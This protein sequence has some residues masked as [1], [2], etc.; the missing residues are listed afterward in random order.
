MKNNISKINYSDFNL[1]IVDDDEDILISYTQNLT[2]LGYKVVCAKNAKEAVRVVR[3]SKEKETE[4][5]V[6]VIDFY[7]PEYSGGDAVKEIREFNKEIVIL[8]Q[9]GFAGD[10]PA[11][12]TLESLKI[13]AYHD[14]TQG[15]DEF[16]VRIISCIRTYMQQRRIAELNKELKL[17]YE[18]IEKLKKNQSLLINATKLSTKGQLIS[19]LPF[20]L[21]STS[22]RS[23]YKIYELEELIE[24]ILHKNVNKD[25]SCIE[26]CE[27]YKKEILAHIESVKEYL[28]TDNN[29]IMSASDDIKEK[30]N[31]YNY[32][33]I[34][35]DDPGA[36]AINMIFGPKTFQ[37]LK[38][39]NTELISGYQSSLIVNDKSLGDI[40]KLKLNG[41]ISVILQVIYSITINLA[42][43]M[44][45]F[46]D[47]D[48][49]DLRKYHEPS[50]G[51]IHMFFIQPANNAPEERKYL[52]FHIGVHNKDIKEKVKENLINDC[53]NNGIALGLF[54]SQLLLKERF[55]GILEYS[56]ISE[57]DESY[58]GLVFTIKIPYSNNS[59][60]DV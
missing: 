23:F 2:N 39:L 29:S 56:E 6:M 17:A 59:I 52:L 14:K 37:F 58:G 16:L 25:S 45:K 7:M 30:L 20:W 35:E 13:Q 24:N 28:I 36:D 51:P 19:N 46:S 10:K 12:E 38:F 27:K 18:S 49:K 60:N 57:D 21:R 47:Y 33:I 55:N 11:I 22:K 40:E 42:K 32:M 48:R 31:Q 4:I 26:E 34:E 41:D 53:K 54:S 5:H 8:L 9:T 15:F 44:F 50:A 3:E 1:L 43:Y